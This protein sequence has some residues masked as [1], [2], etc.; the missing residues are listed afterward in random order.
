VHPAGGNVV[1]YE[2]LSRALNYPFYGLQSVGLNNGERPLRSIEEM[3]NTYLQAIRTVAPSGP[4][5]LAGWS[6]GGVVAYEMA[7]QV[8]LSG[9]EVT[10]LTLLDTDAPALF[11]DT[12]MPMDLRLARAVAEE[13]HVVFGRTVYLDETAL[14]AMQGTKRL[15]YILAAAQEAGVVPYDL[16]TEGMRRLLEVFLANLEAMFS[17]NAE[18][19][20]GSLTVISARD[21]KGSGASQAR[22][23]GWRALVTGPLNICDVPGDHYSFL[24]QKQVGV[25]AQIVDEVLS[26]QAYINAGLR[27]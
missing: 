24:D 3:A 27:R 18:V 6:M 20:A 16:G 10:T 2:A 19:Y 15:N 25:V 26:G 17:Y 1:C 8:V 12:T 5:H 13:N 23:R 21:R 14:R 4:L 9:D 22:D 11:D 7:R